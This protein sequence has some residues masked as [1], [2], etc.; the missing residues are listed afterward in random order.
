MAKINTITT[1][2]NPL[3]NHARESMTNMPLKVV[4]LRLRW[5]AKNYE[6]QEGNKARDTDPVLAGVFRQCNIHHVKHTR[7]M[8][9]SVSNEMRFQLIGIISLK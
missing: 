4:P 5:V 6:A 1:K 7:T 8:P 2:K 9:M 3:K